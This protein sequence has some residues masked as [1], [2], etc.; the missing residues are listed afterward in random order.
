M[1]RKCQ[2][3]SF[4]Q[5]SAV[6]RLTIMAKYPTPGTVKTRLT[7]KLTPEQAA[8]V[9]TVFIRHWIRRVSSL[10]VALPV[11]FA[12]PPEMVLPF[13]ALLPRELFG[14]IE[15]QASGD[16]GERLIDAT[17]RL[18]SPLPFRPFFIGVDSPDVPDATLIH[19][20]RLVKQGTVVIGA[21]GDGGFW[22]VGLGAGVDAATLFRDIEWSSGREASQVIARAQKAGYD[23][24]HAGMWD[25]VDRPDDLRRLMRR[26]KA[27]RVELDRALYRSLKFLPREL[28]A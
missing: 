28:Q 27:S 6:L 17:S 24:R 23:V 7:P 12:D 3:P 26:L 8:R 16:L 4:E 18:Q 5:I 13:A 10:R 14:V 2:D 21:A 9:Q 20:M 11:V 19:A 1:D 15:P 22:S 25:G